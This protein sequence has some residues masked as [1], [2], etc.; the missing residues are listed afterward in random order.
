MGLSLVSMSNSYSD[1]WVV[2]SWCLQFRTPSLNPDSS[3]HNIGWEYSL[4][5]GDVQYA[6]FREN[7]KSVS[8]CNK[9]MESYS[10]WFLRDSSNSFL[11]PLCQSNS[12]ISG[13]VLVEKHC[14]SNQAF[15]C[16]STIFLNW[17]AFG[18]TR[19][20]VQ[21]CLVMKVSCITLVKKFWGRLPY[22]MLC[23]V[24]I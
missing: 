1:E 21:L 12:S 2:C 17:S 7:L 8:I 10:V 14:G 20:P 11:P 15:R 9:T 13:V 22:S 24:L 16:L 6:T 18:S 23:K 5:E 19:S 4:E 3:P